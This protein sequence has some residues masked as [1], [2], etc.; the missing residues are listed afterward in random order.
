MTVTTAH[1]TL[2]TSRAS[3]ATTAAARSSPLAAAVNTRRAETWP[4]MPAR[5]AARTTAGADADASSAPRRRASA[6]SVPSPPD[7]GM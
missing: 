6:G 7:I 4:R 3:S 2:A 5:R 1:S